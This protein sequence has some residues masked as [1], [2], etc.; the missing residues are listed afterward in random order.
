MKA[1]KSNQKTINTPLTASFAWNPVTHD[2]FQ[3]LGSGFIYTMKSLRI[4]A[5]QYGRESNRSRIDFL[6]QPA[7][8][9][10]TNC[11]HYY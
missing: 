2:L 3:I 8:L 6:F 4:E 5:D 7:F 10:E 1:C 9:P 11:Q